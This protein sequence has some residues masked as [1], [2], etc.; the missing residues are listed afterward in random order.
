MIPFNPQDWTGGPGWSG[1]R[2]DDR[3]RPGELNRE[4]A[5]RWLAGAAFCLCFAALGPPH[6]IL[7]AFAGLLFIAALASAVVGTLRAEDPFAPHLTSWDEA[8]VSLLV[9]IGLWLWLGPPPA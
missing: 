1:Q 5:L 8:A 6:L 4:A 2:N 3:R 9:C 7:R